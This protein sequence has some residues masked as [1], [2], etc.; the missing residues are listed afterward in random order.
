MGHI[1]KK[2]TKPVKCFSSNTIKKIKV[3]IYFQL[4]ISVYKSHITALKNINYN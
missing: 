1:C 2:E 4:N 3:V